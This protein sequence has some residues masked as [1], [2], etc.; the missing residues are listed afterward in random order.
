MHEVA[1]HKGQV[2]TEKECS[3]YWHT[4]PVKFFTMTDRESLDYLVIVFFAPLF[5]K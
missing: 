2:I 1:P 4:R 5:L 3:K